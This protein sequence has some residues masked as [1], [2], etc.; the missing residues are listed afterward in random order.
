MLPQKNA[1]GEHRFIAPVADEGGFFL[2]FHLARLGADRGASLLTAAVAEQRD[3][4]E[5]CFRARHHSTSLSPPRRIFTFTLRARTG[6][7]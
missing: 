2:V 3:A 1:T 4:R 7:T 5:R 6:A